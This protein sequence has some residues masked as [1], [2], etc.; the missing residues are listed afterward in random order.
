[1]ATA[2]IQV[3]QPSAEQL[4]ALGVA[5]WPVWQK[6]VSR[7]PWHYSSEETAYLLAGAVTVTPKGGAPVSLVAGDLVTFAAGLECVWEVTQ[8]LRKHYRF[9]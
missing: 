2:E 9:A 1:M 7:F 5:D 8:P 3:V 4:A 6:E